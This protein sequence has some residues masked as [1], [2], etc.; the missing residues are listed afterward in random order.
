MLELEQHASGHA[1]LTAARRGDMDPNAGDDTGSD[2][3]LLTRFWYALLDL[4]PQDGDFE[5]GLG[6]LHAEMGETDSA[7]VQKGSSLDVLSASG[8]VGLLDPESARFGVL[9]SAQAASLKWIFGHNSFG[10]QELDVNAGRVQMEESVGRDGATMGFGAS[11]ADAAVT[12][13]Q[14]SKDSQADTQVK[15]GGGIGL[16]F[17]GALHWS[18]DDKDGARE[19][20]FGVDFKFISLD[21][22]SESL[23]EMWNMAVPGV[24]FPTAEPT[25]RLEGGI[26]PLHY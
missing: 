11:V 19:Y 3:G 8:K 10:I 18:D 26:K 5:F 20:G 15:V 9:A 1:G 12:F 7:E 2:Q 4:D 22:K 23:D 25:R 24:P 21:Y 17:G 16:G 6:L 13:G 14:P